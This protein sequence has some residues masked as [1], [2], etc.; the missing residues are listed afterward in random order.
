MDLTIILPAYNE[1]KIIGTTIRRINNFLQSQNLSFEIIVVNDGST[2]Q[3]AK[4]VSQLN[5]TNLVLLK[6]EKNQGKG[7]AV[8][9]GALASRGELILFLDADYSTSIENLPSFIDLMQKNKA[10]IVIASR[11]LPSSVI[12]VPQ[13]KLKEILGKLGNL[14][15]RF[16]LVKGIKDTQCGFKLF[17]RDCLRLFNL[18]RLKRW[19]FDFELLFL[20]Q[21]YSYKILELP[22]VWTN[23]PYSR[24]KFFDYFRTLTELLSVRYNNLMRKY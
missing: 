3:T 9:K 21:K 1:E 7:A 15:I 8:K 22:V 24:V 12:S 10:D 20:A 5:L 11:A 18:Q 23:N 14:P 17:K 19:G 16:F 13:S 4:V 6:N 2:D